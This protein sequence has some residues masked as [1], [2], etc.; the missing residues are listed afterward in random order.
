VE[1]IMADT[2]DMLAVHRAF[3]QEFDRLG[4]LVAAVPDG[5]VDRART[6]GDHVLAMLTMVHSHH[7]SEDEVL[8]P[9]LEE[10]APERSALASQMAGQHELIDGLLSAASTATQRWMMTGSSSAAS[11]VI[12]CMEQM[13]QN[14]DGHLTDEEAGVLPLAEELFTQAE[15]ARIGEHSRAGLTAQ[16]LDIALGV[17][18]DAASPEE[19]ALIWA[20]LPAER[21]DEW[22]ATGRQAFSDYRA[23]VNGS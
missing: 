23:R 8:W 9:I 2:R 7:T 6:V 4:E 15:W 19:W 22:D 14:M 21:R 16:Q 18:E 13:S 3:R 17:V 10:R 11:D 12:W 20:D 5:D 1:R